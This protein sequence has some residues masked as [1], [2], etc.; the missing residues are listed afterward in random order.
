VYAPG[1]AQCDSDG[2]YKVQKFDLDEESDPL[3]SDEKDYE[4][5][6]NILDEQMSES[7]EGDLMEIENVMKQSVGLY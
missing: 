2:S 3:V 4:P 1:P 6:E 5:L 7:L